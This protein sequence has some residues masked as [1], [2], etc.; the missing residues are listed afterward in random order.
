MASVYPIFSPRYAR[1]R[2]LLRCV[3]VYAGGLQARGVLLPGLRKLHDALSAKAT[4]WEDVI[5]IGRT[6][7]QDATPLTLGQEFGGYA[8]QVFFAA[9]D[10]FGWRVSVVSLILVRF[11]ATVGWFGLFGCTRTGLLPSVQ[12]YSVV[13]GVRE[14][15]CSSVSPEQGM[16]SGRLLCPTRLMHRVQMCATLGIN[17]NRCPPPNTLRGLRLS[18]FGLSKHDWGAQGGVWDR[19]RG[20]SV[21]GAV[22]P[23]LGGYRSWDWPQHRQGTILSRKLVVFISWFCPRIRWRSWGYGRLGLVDG[24]KI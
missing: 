24:K 4:E 17:I 13:A 16:I 1:I 20:S 19:S 7:T 15:R 12:Q 18:P 10:S 5:K 23:G 3:Y 21:A 9:P 6:H 2:C 11:E 14:L 8:A 22:P